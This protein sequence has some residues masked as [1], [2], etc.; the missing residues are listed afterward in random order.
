M[1]K[2]DLL[3]L[4]DDANSL[5]DDD[6]LSLASVEWHARGAEHE[7]VPDYIVVAVIEDVT[8]ELW[9]SRAEFFTYTEWLI[10]DG[11]SVNE[12]IAR[13][14]TSISSALSELLVNA[15]SDY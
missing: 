2:K 1:R 11:D 4:I 10:A 15:N 14:V 3:E 13:R 12:Q 7:G 9:R 8:I 5:T 6:Y